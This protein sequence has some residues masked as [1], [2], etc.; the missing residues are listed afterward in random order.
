M[1][2]RILSYYHNT[3]HPWDYWITYLKR[4]QNNTM[5]FGFCLNSLQDKT[6]YH[7]FVFPNLREIAEKIFY[8]KTHKHIKDEMGKEGR[9][10]GI[11][12]YNLKNVINI[13]LHYCTKIQR[14]DNES[15]DH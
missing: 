1:I 5:K 12:E 3:V 8:L 7:S 15:F 2:Q 9:K 4:K 6:A 14:T 13:F 11:Q 10:R